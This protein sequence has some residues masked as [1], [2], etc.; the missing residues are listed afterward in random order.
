MKETL[1]TYVRGIW[2][3]RM[4]LAY[5]LLVSLSM[6][7]ISPFL[8]IMIKSVGKDWF[9]KRW[10]PPTLTLEWYK[11]AID[12]ADIPR[13]MKNTLV[14]AA[15]AI[16][17]STTIGIFTGWAFGRR[18]LPGKEA[19]MSIILLPRMIP[20]IAYALGVAQIFYALK[21]VNTHLGVAL[22]HVAICAP[23]AILVLSATFESLDERVLEAA[24]VCGA[25]PVRTFLHV[26]LPMIMPGILSS[27]IFTFSHSYNEFTLTLMTY[28]PNTMTLPVRTYLAVGEGYWEVTSAMSV[29]LVIPSLLI[30]LLI[31][32]QV[33]P[34][35][36][37]GGFKGV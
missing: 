31:Q 2:H 33:A 6:F 36:L 26:T 30:L 16:L 22:A 3:G 13:V 5:T 19:L 14:I 20:P 18:H 34:E 23:Y 25:S 24:G 7:I 1:Q 32:R 4:I 15:L 12:I 37:L 11:W 35:K 21:L 28:G 10:L 17:I 29:I 9:G 8:L 27:M